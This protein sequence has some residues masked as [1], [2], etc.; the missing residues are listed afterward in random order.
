MFSLYFVPWLPLAI[1]GIQHR[2]LCLRHHRH[3]AYDQPVGRHD[4]RHTLAGGPRT[5]RAL[6]GPGEFVSVSLTEGQGTERKIKVAS[7]A[8]D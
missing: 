3:T 2:L 7:R 1:F 8:G 6:E 5:G 4:G